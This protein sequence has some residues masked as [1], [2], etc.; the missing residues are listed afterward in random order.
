MVTLADVILEENIPAVRQFLQHGVDVNE[1]DEYGFR[2]LIEAAI[3]DNI[4]IANY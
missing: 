1:I 4:E 2:P 3:A